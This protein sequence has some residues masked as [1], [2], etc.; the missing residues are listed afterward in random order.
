MGHYESMIGR[1]KRNVKTIILTAAVTSL[2]ATYDLRS[3]VQ[4]RNRSGL[5]RTFPSTSTSS[6]SSTFDEKEEDHT[7]HDI[8]SPYSQNIAR[9]YL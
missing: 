1:A 3:L 2:S 4:M 7:I 6:I 9:K 5:V 8:A